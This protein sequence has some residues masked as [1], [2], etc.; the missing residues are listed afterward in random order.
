MKLCPCDSGKPREEL[1]DARGIFCCFICSECEQDKRG[2]YRADIFEDDQYETD[3][4]VEDD[5]FGSDDK[6][7]WAGFKI[8]F[9]TLEEDE[10]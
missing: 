9:M 5:Q 7:V 2:R 8:E 4:P 10:E 6:R 1:I 3:E